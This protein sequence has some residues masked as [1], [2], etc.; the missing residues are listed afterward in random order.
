MDAGLDNT[1]VI[2]IWKNGKIIQDK[3]SRGQEIQ[4]NTTIK[5][6]KQTKNIPAEKSGGKLL[7]NN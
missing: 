1:Q 5:S 2:K 3:S 4:I 6:A 7:A